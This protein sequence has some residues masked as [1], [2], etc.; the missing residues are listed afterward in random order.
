MLRYNLIKLTNNKTSSIIG[1]MEDGD[2]RDV[3]VKSGGGHTPVH[4]KRIKASH[5]LFQK[6]IPHRWNPGRHAGKRSIT[7]VTSVYNW[8][9]AGRELKQGQHIYHIDGDKFNDDI[10]NLIALTVQEKCKLIKFM[11]N[12][13][14]V[15]LPKGLIET[16]IELLRLNT[17]I[18]EGERNE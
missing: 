4:A 1:T 11:Q 18:T 3:M 9:A 10:D 17:K 5:P 8:I 6:L 12:Y 2:I 14:N 13:K 15:K 16:Y 7:V